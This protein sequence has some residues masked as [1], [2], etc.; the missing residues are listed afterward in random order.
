MLQISR[1]SEK[2]QCHHNRHNLL[3]WRHCQNFRGCR[4][5]LVKFSYWSEV[6]VNIITGSGVMTIIV[7]KG[8]IKNPKI[9]NTPGWGLPNIWRLG[10]VRDTK[11]GT[12]VSNKKLLNAPKCQ[13]YSLTISESYL[14]V[15]ES[16]QTLLQVLAK[17]LL[18]FRFRLSFFAPKQSSLMFVFSIWLILLSTII[19]QSLIGLRNVFG[20]AF[21]VFF[22]NYTWKCDTCLR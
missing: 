9:G 21:P 14:T 6:H 2:W 16:N 4:V 8:L 19:L 11:F 12:N 17:Q 18:P 3:T 10:Q 5:S 20:N 22:V 15:S 13:G 7:Y 1:K